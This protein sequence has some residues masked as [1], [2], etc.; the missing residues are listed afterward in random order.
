MGHDGVQDLLWA[1]ALDDG[2]S[3]SSAAWVVRGPFGGVMTPSHPRAEPLY[4]LPA[5]AA[6]EPTWLWAV[7]A[8]D[9]TG[10]GRP[11]LLLGVFPGGEPQLEPPE[12][13]VF[14][15]PSG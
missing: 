5:G 1:T 6:G 14:L 2:A 9:L 15:N 11:E 3:Y 12:V 13:R 4:S 10:D 8:G 7:P